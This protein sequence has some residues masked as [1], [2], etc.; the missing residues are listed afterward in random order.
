MES[1]SAL[2]DLNS[3]PLSPPAHH[4]PFTPTV[5]TD[6][7]HM[8]STTYMYEAPPTLVSSIRAMDSNLPISC[9]NSVSRVSLSH[10][11][12]EMPIPLMERVCTV[13]IEAPLS[14]E[15]GDRQLRS[16]VVRQGFGLSKSAVG[17]SRRTT[18]HRSFPSVQPRQKRKHPDDTVT[19]PTGGH[20]LVPVC[21]GAESRTS[22][23]LQSKKRRVSEGN[24]PS[25]ITPTSRR[26]V[27]SPTPRGI[28]KKTAKTPVI[29]PKEKEVSEATGM[30]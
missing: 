19:T 2:P 25:T 17:G 6:L 8:M 18:P 7:G 3:S 5:S 14:S 15:S 27:S 16:R 21:R 30:C 1:V 10:A 20:I 22:Q 28:E 4:S 26:H 24:G 13:A 9:S 29:A 11:H 23:S 12:S